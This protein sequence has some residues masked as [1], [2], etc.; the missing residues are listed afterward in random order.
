[1]KVRLISIISVLLVLCS[2]TF[3]LAQSDWTWLYKK[4]LN[5][6]ERS[7]YKKEFVFEKNNIPEYSQLILSW[8]AFRPS[9]GHFSFYVQVKDSKTKKWHSYHKMADWGKNIQKSYY[10]QFN[11]NGS[12]GCYVRLEMP[13]N[14]LSS[15]FRVKVVANK[16]LNFLGFIQLSVSVSNLRIFGREKKASFAKLPATRVNGW[17]PRFSQ[18]TLNHPRAEHLCSPT[19]MSMLVS[20]LKKRKINPV[21]FATRAY[22][23]GLDVFGSWPFNT[24]A[25]FEMCD[26]SF[27][28]HVQRLGSFLNLYNYLNKNIP[29]VV[30]VRGSLPGAPKVYNNGHLLVVAGWNKKNKKVVCYDPAFKKSHKVIREYDLGSFL[31][32]WESSHR[33]AY[34]AQPNIKKA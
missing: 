4:R 24:A 2:S 31:S 10:S 12:K 34:I 13:K 11:K 33:L 22:D 1:M 5:K 20:Y 23:G 17:I 26:G 29:V 8:N 25:A 28:F 7:H 6:F 9:R 15:A 21:K 14:K 27:T 16:K 32:A 30:S 19:S 3:V 18:M